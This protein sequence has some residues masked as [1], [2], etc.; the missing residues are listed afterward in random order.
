[1]SQSRSWSIIKN[2]ATR[3][4]GKAVLGSLLATAGYIAMHKFGVDM[5]MA[6]EGGTNV[7]GD[8][9]NNVVNLDVPVLG[10]ATVGAAIGL[11]QKMKGGEGRS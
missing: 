1:M 3:V 9:K 8:I 11:W 7:F 6:F 5:N 10:G 2:P 4:A